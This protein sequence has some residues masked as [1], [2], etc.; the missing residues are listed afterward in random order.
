MEAWR[1]VSLIPRIPRRSRGQRSLT[2]SSMR[3]PKSVEVEEALASRQDPQSNIKNKIVRAVATIAGTATTVP[4]HV[5]SR[6][7]VKN[8]IVG[9]FALQSARLDATRDMV[10]HPPI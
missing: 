9:V 6:E 1:R 4:P 8:R 10:Y 2:L 5:L 7:V 3:T